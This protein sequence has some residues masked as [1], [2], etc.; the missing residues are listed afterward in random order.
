MAVWSVRI[1]SDTRLGMQAMTIGDDFQKMFKMGDK[2]YV[3]LPGMATDV[4]TL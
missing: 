4:Q 1:R 2:L 3:G